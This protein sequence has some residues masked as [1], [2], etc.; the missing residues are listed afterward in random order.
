MTAPARVTRMPT[1]GQRDPYAPTPQDTKRAQDMQKALDAYGGTF[2]GGDAQWPL[3]WKEDKEPNPNVI[4]N[5]CGPAVDTDVAWLFGE[6]VGISLPK[7]A[8]KE[9]QD[10]VDQAW[11]VNSEDSSDD[12]KMSLLQELGTN[13]AITG[14]TFLKMVWDETSDQEFPQLVVLDSQTVRVQ[15]DPHNCKIPVCYLIEYRVPDPYGQHGEQGTFRQ[16]IKRID[17]DGQ[18]SVTGVPDDDTTWQIAD[19]F[20]SD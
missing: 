3:L 18:D 4:I 14:T 12:E 7:K 15:T 17:P 5:R 8:P 2:H 20:K 11:G 6:S 1:T 16:V 9:A 10:Y 13:G 19:Y